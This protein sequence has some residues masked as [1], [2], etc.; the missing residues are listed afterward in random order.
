MIS[1]KTGIYTDEITNL[2]IW[3]NHSAT[4]YPDTYH[5]S[6]RG[7][8]LRKVV[9]DNAWLDGAF[10]SS[11]QQR[12]AEIISVMGKSSAASAASAVCDHVHD[13]WFGTKPGQCT[14][15]GVISDSNN[16]N[17]PLGIVYSFPVQISEG[18]WKIVDNLPIDKFSRQKM[19][20]SSQELLEERKLALGF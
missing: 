13:L 4:Q 3:G 1:A 9:K 7:K 16:Y 20:K 15:M 5:A 18:K 2:C 11:V 14:S 17:I 10:I 19:D 8:P 6:A 12:G